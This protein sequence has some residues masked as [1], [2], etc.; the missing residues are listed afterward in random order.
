MLQ[1]MYFYRKYTNLNFQ[2]V[3]FHITLVLDPKNREYSMPAWI[4]ERKCYVS[5]FFHINLSKHMVDRPV[6]LSIAS[7]PGPPRQ[8]VSDYVL[9]NSHDCSLSTHAEFFQK[10]KKL[11]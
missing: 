1:G 9:A 4:G 8:L 6:T 7:G 10:R 11:P 2:S 5:P 3:V